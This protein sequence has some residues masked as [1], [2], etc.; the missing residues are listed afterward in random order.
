MKDFEPEISSV[1][2]IPADS[3]K[4]EVVVNGKLIYSKTKTGRHAD[5]GEVISL[6][7]EYLKK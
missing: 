7:K 6:V 1:T 2:L 4:F 5:P 3:G